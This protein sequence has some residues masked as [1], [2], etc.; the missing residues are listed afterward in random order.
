MAKVRPTTYIAAVSGRLAPGE[1]SYL[2]TNKHT[3]RTYVVHVKHPY[4]GPWS[5]KQVAHRK[6]F[7]QRSKTASAWLRANAP[8]Y[9]GGVATAEYKAMMRRFRAQ[10]DTGNIF[11]FVAKHYENGKIKSF[12]RK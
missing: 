6:A 1:D 3:G 4:R 10:T 7:A 2:A 12:I 9:R 5:D 11:S 8:K